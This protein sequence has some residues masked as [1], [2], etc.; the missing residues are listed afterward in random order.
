MRKYKGNFDRIKILE[1]NFW[2]LLLFYSAILFYEVY[3]SQ[4]FRN[5]SNLYGHSTR[6]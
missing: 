3:F 1:L 6:N 5:Y 4:L 2:D